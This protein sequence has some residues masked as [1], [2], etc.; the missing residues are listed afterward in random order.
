MNVITHPC[1]IKVNL[2]SAKVRLCHRIDKENCDI[3][4]CASDPLC[5]FC[6]GLQELY[7]I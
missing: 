4:Y 3:V 1:Q 7:I 2:S 6:M 5:D